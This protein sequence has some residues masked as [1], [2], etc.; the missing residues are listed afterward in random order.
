MFETLFIRILKPALN[1]QRDPIYLALSCFNF[2]YIYI[3]SLGDFIVSVSFFIF[4][5]IFFP[6]NNMCILTSLSIRS[7]YSTPLDNGVRSTPKRRS[8]SVHLL[9]GFLILPKC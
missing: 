7:I 1:K 9:L 6:K 8:Y 4:I 3:A 2:F 5:S